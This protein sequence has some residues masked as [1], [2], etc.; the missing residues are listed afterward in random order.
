M[1]CK[2]VV[3]HRLRPPKKGCRGLAFSVCGNPG[4][5]AV[6]GSVAG[7]NMVIRVGICKDIRPP[8]YSAMA[9]GKRDLCA[10]G[11]TAVGLGILAPD[12]PEAVI[13]MK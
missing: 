11:Q 12:G 10:F 6:D 7:V 1:G 4:L 13:G 8:P 3:L 2:H 9:W 5:S